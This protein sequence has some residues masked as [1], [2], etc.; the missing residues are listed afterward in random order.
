MRCFVTRPSCQA[1]RYA[2][3]M[4]GP[5][6]EAMTMEVLQEMPEA[7]SGGGEYVSDTKSEAPYLLKPQAS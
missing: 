5:V 2:A 7:R 3:E 4:V 6:A 1:S